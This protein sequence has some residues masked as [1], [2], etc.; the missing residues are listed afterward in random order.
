MKRAFLASLDTFSQ[1]LHKRPRKKSYYHGDNYSHIDLMRMNNALLKMMPVDGFFS[2][3]PTELIFMILDASPISV[4]CALSTSCK[5]LSMLTHQRSQEWCAK[6]EFSRHK[7]NVGFLQKVMHILAKAH[8]IN[9]YSMTEFFQKFQKPKKWIVSIINSRSCH[10]NKILT[11]LDMAPNMVLK[12]G[13]LHWAAW[14]GNM[15]ILRFLIQ[16]N[17]IK[18]QDFLS[19]SKIHYNALS[20]VIGSCRLETVKFLFETLKFTADVI[21][22]DDLDFLMDCHNS[23]YVR[24]YLHE[25]INLCPETVNN[26]GD[27]YLSIVKYL[28]ETVGLTVD[29]VRPLILGE[30]P[31]WL[32]VINCLHDDDVVKYFFTIGLTLEDVRIAL[33]FLCPSEHSD[34]FMFFCEKIKMTADDFRTNTNF[35]H[36]AVNDGRCKVVQY[37]FEHVGLTVDDARENNNSFQDRNNSVLYG[38][39]VHGHL[40]VVKYLVEKVGLTID[41]ARSDNNKIAR[42]TKHLKVVKYLFEHVG[43]TVNDFSANNN[44]VLQEATR[45]S[46][47]DTVKYLTENIK[48]PII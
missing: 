24:D 32:K 26:E 21:S 29:A 37:L 16:E 19:E 14:N 42:H 11:A 28:F 9:D 17:G 34:I 27:E 36:R 20:F 12:S 5:K 22:T 3:L 31:L 6:L 13:L 30:G 47:N 10:T 23:D 38:A 44:E 39:C 46:M 33:P 1:V 45:W 7:T 18:A 4:W 25:S 48:L 41:D 35:L 40:D 43:L 15:D 8:D 2:C